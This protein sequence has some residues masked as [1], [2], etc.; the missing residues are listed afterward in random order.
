MTAT[1]PPCW[2]PGLAPTLEKV[3]LVAGRIAVCWSPGN[4]FSQ[5]QSP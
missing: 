5:T 3:I 2:P 1:V 4:F